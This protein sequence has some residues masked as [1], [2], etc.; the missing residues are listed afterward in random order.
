MQNQTDGGYATYDIHDNADAGHIV[1]TTRTSTGKPWKIEK[2]EGHD[3]YVCVTPC[4][5]LMVVDKKFSWSGS[6]LSGKTCVGRF[7]A[8]DHRLK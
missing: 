1:L 8:K 6:S 2:I 3:A 4:C 7:V 5:N